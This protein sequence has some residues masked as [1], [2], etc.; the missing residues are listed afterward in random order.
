MCTVDA[1]ASN[2]HAIVGANWIILQNN[3]DVATTSTSGYVSA[4]ATSTEAEAK[5]DTSKV[6]TPSS[7]A[8]FS[9]KKIFTV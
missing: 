6:L 2:T 8:N 7:L 1:S 3:L 9:Q 5:S 4:L